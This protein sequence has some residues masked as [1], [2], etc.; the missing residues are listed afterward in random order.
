MKRI[1]I[2]LLIGFQALFC[3]EAEYVTIAILAKDKAHT[4]DLYL[5]CIE[6]QTW[7]KECTYLY[8]RTNNNTDNTAQ[9]LR[10]WLERV[11]DLYAGIFFD[12]SD[13]SE[14]VQ[15]YGQHE[16]NS[17]RFRVLGKIRK[18]SC[19]W[20]RAH[21][22]HYFVADCDNFFHPQVIERLVSS[23]CPVVAPFMTA[24][25]SHYANYHCAVDSRGYYADDPEYHEIYHRRKLGIFKVPL[26]HCTYLIRHEVLDK[27]CYDDSSHR[28][29]YVIFSDMMRKQ[30]VDQYIDNR[31]VYGRITPR[32][33]K[34]EVEQEPWYQEF[35][36][37]QRQLLKNRD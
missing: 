8:I 21:K 37:I 35:L 13:V 24:A 18:D 30:A 9:I 7:P 27:V 19:E 12:D 23:K 32:E 29:E 17:L 6:A 3:S 34:A 11:K 20:A 14:P 22:S 16:W 33:T 28:Y 1:F 4:L 2:F 26:V 10:S 36:D 25:H 31:E 15:Q 5:S